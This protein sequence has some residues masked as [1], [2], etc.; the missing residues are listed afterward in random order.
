MERQFRYAWRDPRS[1]AAWASALAVGL[2]LP[3]IAAAQHGS[4]YTACWAAALLG[5]QIY[6]QFGVDGTAFWTVAATVA[7]REE[8]RA[9]LRGRAGAIASVAIPYVVLVTVGAALLLGRAGAIP[10]VLGLSFALLGALIATGAYASV[11]FPYSMPHET[12]FGGGSAAPGQGGLAALSLFGGGPLG[13]VLVAPVLALVFALHTSGRH[14]HGLLW[15]ILPVGAAYGAVLAVAG[16]RFAAPRLT[17]R[18]PEILTAV[19]R[20]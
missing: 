6:N 5:L 1:K 17:R 15:L 16:L 2:L 14:G 13:A 19:S 4:V 20:G 18:L 10:E 12:R 3:V 11:R 9:E 8:A 7:T